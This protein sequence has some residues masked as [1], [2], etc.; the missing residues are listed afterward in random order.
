MELKTR[1]WRSSSRQRCS[2]KV[3]L[4]SALAL[5]GSKIE[6]EITSATVGA[7]GVL[8]TESFRRIAL[9]YPQ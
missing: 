3:G 6:H 4:A 1:Q 8:S 5:A 9:F 2:W 7:T